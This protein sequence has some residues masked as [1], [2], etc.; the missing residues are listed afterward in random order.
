MAA[1][2]VAE[3]VEKAT[4]Q[5]LIMPDWDVNMQVRNETTRTELPATAGVMS[6]RESI[7][8]NLG[9]TATRRDALRYGVC[10]FNP[11]A[12]C[13]CNYHRPLQISDHAAASAAAAG[14]AMRAIA[15]KLG[16][17][18]PKVALLALTLADTCVKNGSASVVE[19]AADR[20]LVAAL[21]SFAKDGGGLG[22]EV[23][24]KAA[25][26]LQLLG[27]GTAGH[28]HRLPFPALYHR[29]KAEGARFPAVDVPAVEALKATLAAPPPAPAPAPAAAGPST[30]AAAAP[31]TGDRSRGPAAPA[32]P[33]ADPATVAAALSSALQRL[34]GDLLAVRARIALTAR[35]LVDGAAASPASAPFLDAVDFLAQ[36]SPRLQALVE[37]C[38]AGVIADEAAFDACLGTAEAAARVLE[39]AAPIAALAAPGREAAAAAF[40]PAPCAAV[41][42]LIDMDA[43]GEAEGEVG[44]EGRGLTHPPADAAAEG[45]RPAAAA[46]SKPAAA[47]AADDDLLGL[48]SAGPTPSGAPAPASAAARPASASGGGR[49]SLGSA[50]AASGG[51]V[52]A[53]SPGPAA[54]AAAPTAASAVSLASF[55]QSSSAAAAAAPNPFEDFGAAAPSATAGAP[56]GGGDSDP[57]ASLPASRPAAGEGDL[58]A[59]PAAPGSAGKPAA[60]AAAGAPAAAGASSS[61][62]G[63]ADSVL[64]DLDSLLA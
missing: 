30:G 20:E 60:A 12:S 62:G 13:D 56:S 57:F 45:R 43:E 32:P 53:P 1:A 29:L 18:N 49:A 16:V 58:F 42:D 17:R 22:G 46:V 10:P 51:G 25:D 7:E 63:D 11:R 23:Q 50:A 4:S 19:A 3:A 33:A 27:L 64:R 61:S 14:A 31:A 9:R 41:A 15:K 44:G 26:L 55:E 52:A 47:A 6:G 8:P 2:G 48:F 39:H 40:T 21:S 36:A 54:A 28:E 59:A 38:A 34:R 5:L 37:A 35:M 24:E